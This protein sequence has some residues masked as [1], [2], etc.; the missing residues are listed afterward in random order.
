MDPLKHSWFSS[1]RKRG[2]NFS[3]VTKLGLPADI[4]GMHASSK[5]EYFTLYFVFCLFYNLC[6]QTVSQYVFLPWS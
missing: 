5:F 6:N 2:G 4:F 1:E 3:P